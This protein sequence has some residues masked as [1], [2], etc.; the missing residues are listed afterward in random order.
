[1]GNTTKKCFICQDEAF[2]L[3]FPGL[4]FF[5]Y[6]LYLCGVKVRNAINAY[7]QYLETEQRRS[8]NTVIT[9]RTVFDDF[10]R[11]LDEQGI[12]KVNEIT[13]REVR[14][15]QAMH[16]ES[17]D[18]TN[19]ILKRLTAL[20][21]WFTYMRRQKWVKTDV[22]AKI[23]NPK[24]PHALPI[25]FREKEVEKIYNDNL[26]PDNMEGE[27][28]KLLL[29]ILYE[30]GI[31][32]SEAVGLTEASVDLSNLSIKVRG[33]RDKERI[34]PIEEE[35]AQGIRNY[36]E[37]KHQLPAYDESLFVN[38]DGSATNYNKVYAIVKKYM[39]LLSN[40]DRISPHIFRHTFATQMLNEGASINAI[41]ELL[42][43]ASIT[44]TEVYT[45]VTREYL[46]DVYKHAHPRVARKSPLPDQSVKK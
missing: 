39:S 19:T 11:I 35:L 31:R 32:R 4:P 38:A 22:M 18:A 30:T 43:H 5:K 8:Q 10:A 12:T 33:K 28:D 15:W 1:M 6:Y 16:A 20:R 25:F 9:Y 27:R 29:R 42:G 45:H 34:I 24:R 40:A 46:K 17:G 3:F 13:S 36:L 2:F 7:L 26:F 14:D 44:T 23:S 41:K 21:S 37:R